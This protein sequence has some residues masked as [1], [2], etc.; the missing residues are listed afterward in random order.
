MRRKTDSVVQSIDCDVEVGG[1]LSSMQ[2]AIVAQETLRHLLFMRNQIPSLFH[3]LADKVL[4]S[5]WCR[6]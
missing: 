5:T 2:A 3:E 4:V 6:P 1:P